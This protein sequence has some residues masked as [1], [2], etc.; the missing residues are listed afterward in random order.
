MEKK[1]AR[2]EKQYGWQLKDGCYVQD[3][4]KWRIMEL[5]DEK[6]YG[7]T[8]TDGCYVQDG[9]NNGAPG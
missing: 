2:D 6:Q 7:W 1:G 4:S 9:E 8:L 5:R 3:G